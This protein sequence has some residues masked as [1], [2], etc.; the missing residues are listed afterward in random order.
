MTFFYKTLHWPTCPFCGL[1]DVLALDIVCSCLPMNSFV[2]LIYETLIPI[3]MLVKVRRSWIIDWLV[4]IG[5]S[6]V[7]VVWVYCIINHF[8]CLTQF[9]SFGSAV[10]A[11]FFF[12]PVLSCLSFWFV[13]ISVF[14]LLMFS[15]L[16]TFFYTY[17]L[18]LSN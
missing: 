7:F 18:G 2:A 13:F 4:F 9:L 16:L 6:L 14:Y 8:F 10:L 5:L 3:F 11:G 15:F 12:C 17:S 1:L